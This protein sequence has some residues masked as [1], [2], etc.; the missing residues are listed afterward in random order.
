MTT[1]HG[2][3][4]RGLFWIGYSA[5]WSVSAAY[6]AITNSACESDHWKLSKHRETWLVQNVT[7]N[8]VFCK[9]RSHS[10]RI[11]QILHILKIAA[12]LNLWSDYKTILGERYSEFFFLIRDRKRLSRNRMLLCFSS[13]SLGS[14][15]I[16]YWLCDLSSAIKLVFIIISI[17]DQNRSSFSK[18]LQ[19]LN[20]SRVSVA[21]ICSM[22]IESS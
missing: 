13:C 6:L 16:L 19:S 11:M 7:L 12:F 10:L 5:V 20:R 3:R 15:A 2:R 9:T 21:K 18:K 8:T 17:A 1:G 4:K 14:T 22:I